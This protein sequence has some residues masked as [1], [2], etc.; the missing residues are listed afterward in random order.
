MMRHIGLLAFV[1]FSTPSLVHA[2]HN[3]P[4]AFQHAGTLSGTGSVVAEF[5]EIRKIN[6]PADATID[7]TYQQT[8]VRSYGGSVRG[9]SGN[10]LASEIPKGILVIPYGSTDLEKGWSVS[11]PKLIAIKDPGTQT[12]VGYRFE[13]KLYCTVGSS[14]SQNVGG[15]SVGVD[16]CYR[17]RR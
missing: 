11:A 6:L 10:M 1:V 9:R 14:V 17:P 7:T 2:Q 13:M 16:V 8:N 3:C 4:Q 15:C 12:V 5:N